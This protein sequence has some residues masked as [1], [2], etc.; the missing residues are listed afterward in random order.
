MMV[1]LEENMENYVISFNRGIVLFMYYYSFV[2]ILHAI[3]Y[4]IKY[5]YLI[6][7]LFAL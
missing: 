6:L 7:L 4:K 2:N 5:N 1:L 3:K